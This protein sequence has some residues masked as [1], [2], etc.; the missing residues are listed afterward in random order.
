M[1]LIY[2]LIGVCVVALISLIYSYYLDWR[3]AKHSSI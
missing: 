3:D 1:A 2:F